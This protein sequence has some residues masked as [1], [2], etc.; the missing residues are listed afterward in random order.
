MMSEQH[1]LTE[2]AS[3]LCQAICLDCADRVAG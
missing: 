3:A 2:C 1:P